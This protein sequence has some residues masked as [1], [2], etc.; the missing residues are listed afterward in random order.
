M[1]NLTRNASSLRNAAV[2][3]LLAVPLSACMVGPDYRR[4]DVDVPAAWRLGITEASAIANITPA[5]PRRASAA[6]RTLPCPAAGSST[7]TG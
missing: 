7:T 5:S 6:A 3:L 1:F 4:P 2:A